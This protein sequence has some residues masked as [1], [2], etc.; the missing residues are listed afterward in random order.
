MISDA[1]FLVVVRCFKNNLFF[2]PTFKE[3]EGDT[4]SSI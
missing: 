4:S 2:L 3:F 1:F